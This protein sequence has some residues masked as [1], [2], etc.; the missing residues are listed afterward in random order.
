MSS[1]T[2]SLAVGERRLRTV[3]VL[4]DR[5][6]VRRAVRV[7]VVEHDPAYREAL[8][9]G[10]AAKGY[11]VDHAHDALEGLRRFVQDP[12]DIVVIDV[13]LPGI[14]ATDVCVRMRAM[15]EVPVIMITS[16]E[17]EFDITRALDAGAVDY[18]ARPHRMRELAA[19]IEA[20]RRPVT[21]PP[22]WVQPS[23]APETLRKGIIN[24]G[25]LRVDCDSRRVTVGG[26][27]VHLPR[28]EF[29]LL[30][31]LLSPPGRLWSRSELIDRLWS[32]RHGAGSRT[33]DTH[34]RR[35]RQKLEGEK[36]RERHL[37]TVRGVGFRYDVGP[38]AIGDDTLGSAP[39]H[40]S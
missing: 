35:L 31:L 20:V 9:Q 6:A 28:R 24:V 8:Q 25:A 10:L 39:S 18:V 38:L 23:K 19:R 5:R 27:V 30:A 1:V 13:L 33:L 14:P 7:L 17:T 26:H 11:A 34:I 2:R 36:G 32:D 16:V 37:V 3:P 29:D 15:A 21:P 12:P 4:V 40:A 22:R